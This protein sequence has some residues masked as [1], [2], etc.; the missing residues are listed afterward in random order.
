MK[1]IPQELIRQAAKLLDA[2]P[3]SHNHIIEVHFNEADE[4]VEVWNMLADEEHIVASVQGD[5][6]Y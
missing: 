6:D 2:V 4:R 1:T 3:D 5:Y